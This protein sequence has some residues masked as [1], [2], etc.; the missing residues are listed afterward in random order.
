MRAYS[1][2]HSEHFAQL[3]AALDAVPGSSG[4]LLDETIVV[5]VG[6]LADGAHGLNRWPVVVAG[7]RGL[8]LGRWIQFEQT[9]RVTH[10][11]NTGQLGGDYMGRP[12]HHMLVTLAQVMGLDVDHVGLDSCVDDNGNTVDLSGPISELLV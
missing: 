7:G 9:V 10:G 5:W 1:R 3:L 11:Q 6:E 12:H 2:K 8:Q 4:T